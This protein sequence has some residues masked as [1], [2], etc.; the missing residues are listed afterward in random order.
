MPRT[1]GEWIGATPDSPPP[2]RVRVRIFDAN[3]GRCH[4]SGRT[5]QAGEPWDADH[6]IPL[7]AGGENRESNLRPA[8]RDKHRRKTAIEVAEKS[9]VAITRKAHLGVKAS[10]AVKIKS[11]GFPKRERMGKASLPPLQLYRMA[12]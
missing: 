8:L 3:G 10:P 2:P 7:V 5:I 4:I 12:R 9:A 6:V 1:V 11:A